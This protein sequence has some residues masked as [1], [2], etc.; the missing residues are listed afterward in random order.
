MFVVL[1]QPMRQ[2]QPRTLAE[3]L[4]AHFG[5]A[6]TGEWGR[7]HVWCDVTKRRRLLPRG[8]VGHQSVF[9]DGSQ[10]PLEYWAM[11]LLP[12]CP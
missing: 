2:W 8:L 3:S 6:S 11:D 10:I 7:P 9:A 1:V 5:S 12:A 4:R